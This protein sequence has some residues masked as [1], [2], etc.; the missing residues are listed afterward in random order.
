MMSFDFVHLLY[1]KSLLSIKRKFKHFI[2]IRENIFVKLISFSVLLLNPDLFK[3]QIITTV[4]G[5]G[6][7]TYNGNNLPALSSALQLPEG[8][9]DMDASGNIYF[10]DY[11][12]NRVRK[13]NVS[14]GI[15][16]NI[17]GN[18]S[19]G[20][21]GDGGLATS[22][23]IWG[24]CAVKVDKI[25]NVYIADYS[26]NRIRMV[27]VA[28]GTIT[29]IAGTGVGTYSLNNVLAVNASFPSP[30]GIAID[31]IG[32]VYFSHPGGYVRKIDKATGIISIVAGTGTS[33][34]NGDG[35]LAT[36][37]QLNTP[38]GLA[39][40]KFQNLY[41]ADRGGY[42]I[43]KISAA[44]GSISTVA[45]NGI[46]GNSG[47]GAAATLANLKD[48]WDVAVDTSGN[49][50]IADRF[51]CKIR[52]VNSSGIISIYAGTGSAGFSGDGGSATTAQLQSPSG[53]CV[54]AC[55]GLIITDRGNS[56][57]RKVSSF[58][59]SATSGDA[60]CFGS[61]NGTINSIAS[62]GLSPYTYTWTGLGSGS[63]YTN[64]CAGSYL[65]S[66][67]D[68][69]GCK[70]QL[71]VVINEPTQFI[72]AS[73]SQTN[74]TCNSNGKASVSLSGGSGSPYTYTWT[75]GTTVVTSTIATN[76]TSGT[77][78]VFVKDV[79]GCMATK[80]LSILFTPTLGITINTTD[81]T[82]GSLGS[83]T[84]IPS[85]TGPF[86]YSW[87]TGATTN[88]VNSLT[89][90]NYTVNVIDANGCSLSQTCSI[91]IITPTFASVPICFVTVD[92]LSQYNVITWEK[93]L[94]PMA[95]SFFVYREIGTNLYKKI[96]SQPYS[97]YSQFTDTVRT[98]YFP[99]TGDPN[100]GT[101]RYKLMTRDS[102]GNYSSFSPYHNTLF[103]VNSN[104]TFSW[105]QL[106]TIEGDPNP[107]LSYI[108]ERDNMSTGNW[109]AVGSVSGTQSFIIDPNYTT[110]QSTGSWRVR[111][112]WSINCAPSQKTQVVNSKS[113]SN[114]I[115]NNAIGIKETKIEG[116]VSLY[117][118]PSN[119]IFTAKFNNT[120]EVNFV[121]YN[122]TG[123]KVYSYSG[124]SLNPI[125]IDLSKN[126]N[127]IY[128]AVINSD[129]KTCTTKLIIQ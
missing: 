123:E 26:N 89:A 39:F 129:N 81:A 87:S 51:D 124:P 128:F 22:A 94:F 73:S 59:F 102:C 74:V 82:C 121:I 95:D 67:T 9:L 65:G 84:V 109:A 30:T 92:S 23:Q 116:L 114:R 110:Y 115:K 4:I 54:N 46:Y 8:G 31:S 47:D 27:D 17:A 66:C 88:T 56:R 90:G 16:T 70:E 33:G 72:I 100:V 24:P 76:L 69:R 13:L 48:P 53:V 97:A 86:T 2:M 126:A 29:T 40:D 106:Y 25:G 77:Y 57:I 117:P 12:N 43:R 36:N 45:G 107:V 44:T 93:T 112:Q 61:C 101:Y 99:N 62:G 1:F 14:T 91:A 75:N 108:L 71:S 63:S 41:I 64:V 79:A 80:T 127:G 125:T 15:L 49:M 113:Y 103:T 6:Q 42:R 85:G 21:G 5:N 98:L 11:G 118:N 104:G 60:I 19:T 55:G 28:T 111:T 3:S 83:A 35:I 119:G 105:S 68:S 58:S 96:A 20:F 37:A 34:Y 122:V 32:N 18:G 50:F 78:T 7:Q 10:A 38:Y 120:K 52:K